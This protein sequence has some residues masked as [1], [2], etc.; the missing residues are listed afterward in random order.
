MPKKNMIMDGT[1]NHTNNIYLCTEIELNDI[2]INLDYDDVIL[3]FINK[4]NKFM[5]EVF[6]NKY[7]II[8]NNKIYYDKPHLINVRKYYDFYFNIK[9]NNKTIEFNIKANHA[10]VDTAALLEMLQLICDY[11]YININDFY[12]LSL[13]YDEYMLNNMK[14]IKYLIYN[15]MCLYYFIKMIFINVEKKNLIKNINSC[16]NINKKTY[17]TKLIHKNLDNNNLFYSLFVF[18]NLRNYANNNKNYFGSLV[19]INSINSMNNFDNF[20]HNKIES[21]ILLLLQYYLLINKTIMKSLIYLINKKFLIINN[22]GIIY[23]RHNFL[24]FKWNMYNNYPGSNIH[25]SIVLINPNKT[26]I[27]YEKII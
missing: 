16:N 9:L 19:T 7:F 26:R 14:G 24:S 13:M 21:Y 15:P 10:Y 25:Y 8:L 20:K 23:P 18:V 11:K 4:I 3:F 2:L 6:I 27:N 17:I 1:Y 12:P 5:L 22:M